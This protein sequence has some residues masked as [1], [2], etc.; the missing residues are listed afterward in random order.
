MSQEEVVR[1]TCIFCVFIWY[2]G[3]IVAAGVCESVIPNNGYAL[4]APPY[5]TSNYQLS[6]SVISLQSVIAQRHDYLLTHCGNIVKRGE[7]LRDCS[8]F[9]TNF[10]LI[11]SQF[12]LKFELMLC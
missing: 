6:V 8:R 5:N 2:L 4:A 10:C 11:F 9:N 1:T 7:M 12:F 3:C